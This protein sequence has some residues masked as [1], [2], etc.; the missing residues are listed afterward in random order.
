MRGVIEF[1]LAAA[2]Y[3][4]AGPLLIVVN[5]RILNEIGFPFP[6]ALSALGVAFASFTS[7]ALL[8]TGVMPFSNQPAIY[9]SCR[10]SSWH[11]YFRAAL[12]IG[13][14]SAL[15]LALGNASYQYLSVAMCQILKALTPAMTYALLLVFR[16][17]TPNLTEA[18]C[19]LVITLGTMIAT[20]GDLALSTVGLA[21]QLGANAAEA[22]RLV[23]SQQLLADMRLPLFELQYH[24][25]LPQLLCL[26]AASAIF[27]M[28]TEANRAAAAAA[29]AEHPQ[30]FVV[31]GVLGQLLQVVGLIAV[32][33][34]GSVA[35]KLLGIARG[36]GLVLFEVIVHPEDARPGSLQL[37]GYVASIAGFVV[38]SFARLT[39]A[40]LVETKA[41][42]KSQ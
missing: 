39:A 34:T 15:T 40:P 7:R 42:A 12:P 23:L 4:A 20:H 3:I 27:E 25:A 33:V 28:H 24:V 35:F 6:I 8:L 31:A 1:V 5:N 21:V 30:A 41:K 26:L 29:I 16:I 14:M 13:A 2:G 17:E 37:G 9:D 32:K 38:Y 10:R 36:A 11:F 18:F 19:V 22:L